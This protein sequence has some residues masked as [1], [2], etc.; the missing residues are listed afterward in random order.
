MGILVVREALIPVRGRKPN[1]ELHNKIP[2]P[3]VR[4]ALIPVRGR[5]PADELLGNQI[6]QRVREALIPVRGRKQKPPTPKLPNKL[7]RQRGFNPR[8]GS[9]T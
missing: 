9:E 2:N 5:K 8:K 3:K 1:M 6:I 7:Q 4:E